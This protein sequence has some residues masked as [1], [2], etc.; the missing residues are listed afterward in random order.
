MD[1][2]SSDNSSDE[3]FSDLGLP[4]EEG[5]SAAEKISLG[6]PPEVSIEKEI[7]QKL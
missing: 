6:V 2:D 7:V 1:Q 5:I 4:E 3:L